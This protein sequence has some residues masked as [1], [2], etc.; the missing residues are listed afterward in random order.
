[1][2][3]TAH[4]WALRASL[5]FSNNHLDSVC[6]LLTEL[7]VAI[8]A[9]RKAMPCQP[10]EDPLSRGW[11]AVLTAFLRT[12]PLHAASV[13]LHAHRQRL[14]A[15]KA[16]PVFKLATLHQAAHAW[17]DAMHL[18]GAVV[19]SRMLKVD[20]KAGV[21]AYA[22]VA[23]SHILQHLCA[24][25][26]DMAEGLARVG[27]EEA[28]GG[29]VATAEG[30]RQLSKRLGVTDASLLELVAAMAQGSST[31]GGVVVI[32]RG[33]TVCVEVGMRQ[34]GGSGAEVRSALAHPAVQVLLG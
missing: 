22:D 16:S 11:E 12:Q 25:R 3:L 2:L 34:P 26:L 6:R 19:G 13:V 10:E 4:A 20:R 7:Q 29:D 5:P 17:A 8:D 32:Q 15:C 21:R 14:G 31:G 28:G 33:L 24:L 27:D 18:A 30:V 9:I 23:S 1:M